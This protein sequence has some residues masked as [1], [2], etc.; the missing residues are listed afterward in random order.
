MPKLRNDS[1]GDS[2]SG[3]L[4]CDS[5]ILPLNYQSH[6][7]RSVH[8]IPH[9]IDTYLVLACAF[10]SLP[11]ADFMLP[12][13]CHHLYPHVARKVSLKS[14]HT[15]TVIRHSSLVFTQVTDIWRLV[16]GVVLNGH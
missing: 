7:H 6:K 14:N 10:S 16:T 11:F 13:S 15:K 9:L 3:S 5:R 1:K 4:D 2:N 12:L 8:L